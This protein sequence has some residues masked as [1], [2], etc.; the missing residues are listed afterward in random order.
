MP[1]DAYQGRPDLIMC[2]RTLLGARPAVTQKGDTHYMAPINKD[3]SVYACMKEIQQERVGVFR[4]PQ[5]FNQVHHFTPVICHNFLIRLTIICVI[6][7]HPPDKLGPHGSPLND[8]KSQ[9]ESLYQ[10]QG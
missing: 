1:D 9:G 4:H 5:D 7:A 10:G 3:K 2:G 8:F 6:R